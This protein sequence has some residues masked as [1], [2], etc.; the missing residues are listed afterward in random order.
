MPFAYSFE[1]VI[2]SEAKDLFSSVARK[3]GSFASLRMTNLKN[4]GFPQ[5]H[6]DK[7]NN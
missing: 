6:R 4:L 2:L 1:V 5:T 3:S 7:G